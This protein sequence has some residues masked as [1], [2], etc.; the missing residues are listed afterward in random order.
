MKRENRSTMQQKLDQLQ[1]EA[2]LG[3]SLLSIVLKAIFIALVGFG[4]PAGVTAAFAPMLS[5]A[6][7]GA[8]N[9]FGSKRPRFFF[10]LTE[11]ITCPR[12]SEIVYDEWSDGESTQFRVSC[13][14]A[15]GGET[16]GRT[17]LALAVYLAMWFLGII[18]IALAVMLLQ[19][20]A[21][22]RKY[23]SGG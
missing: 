14:D 1:R 20:A 8:A 3:R 6:S 19:R 18:Y 10:G 11:G 13:L 15:G 23:E 21:A 22:K 5:F 16:R 4:A 17:L 12:G 2:T 7:Q 9:E